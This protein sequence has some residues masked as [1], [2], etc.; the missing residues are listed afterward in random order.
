MINPEIVDRVI[1]LRDNRCY[2]VGLDANGD[3]VERVV[4]LNP[5]DPADVPSRSQAA[6][7]DFVKKLALRGRDG[8]VVSPETLERWWKYV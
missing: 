4:H 1:V 2:L 7:D 3:T 6:R 8:Y 5:K